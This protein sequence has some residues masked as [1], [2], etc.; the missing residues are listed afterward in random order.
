[1][2]N[3]PAPVFSMR[4]EHWRPTSVISKSAYFSMLLFSAFLCCCCLLMFLGAG[5]WMK[6]SQ[7]QR[8][9][10]CSPVSWSPAVTCVH[11]QAEH[12]RNCSSRDP[13]SNGINS[14]PHRGIRR[15]QL[16]TF[17]SFY[18]ICENLIE[19]RN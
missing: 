16:Q 13:G 19:Q 17:F 3:I 11:V 10:Q 12:S 15:S 6:T 7:L 4:T 8:K 2:H 18:F 5:E 9:G 1:M 14:P